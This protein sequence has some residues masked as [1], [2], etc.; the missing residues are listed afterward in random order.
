MIEEMRFS[1][2]LDLLFGYDFGNS[3][4]ELI[5]KQN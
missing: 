4:H 3:I 1:S 2:V 5:K